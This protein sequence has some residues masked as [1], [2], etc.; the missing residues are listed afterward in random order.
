MESGGQFASTKR[1]GDSL[2]SS[3]NKYS[4]Q[5][6]HYFIHQWRT[7]VRS[8]SLSILPH[9]NPSR[10]CLLAQYAHQVP[11]SVQINIANYILA[12]PTTAQSIATYADPSGHSAL[13]VSH[14]D[15]LQHFAASDIIATGSSAGALIHSAPEVQGISG[16]VITQDDTH[17]TVWG[18][19][20]AKQLVYLT[21][22]TTTL[23]LGQDKPFVLQSTPSREFA[24][25]ISRPDSVTNRPELSQSIIVKN[26]DSQFSM[27][28]Q[29]SNTGLWKSEPFYIQHDTEIVEVPS[30][31]ITIKTSGPDGQPCVAGS[32]VCIKASSA[33]N[34]VVNGKSITIGSVPEWLPLD[35]DGGLHLIVS[36]Q[37][38]NSTTLEINGIRDDKQVAMNLD[39]SVV[40][41]PNRKAMNA[42]GNITDWQV[43]KGAKTQD[44]TPLFDPDQMP[45]DQDLQDAVKYFQTLHS[46]Y[47]SV[48][49]DG[50]TAPAPA[51]QPQPVQKMVSAQPAG[52]FVPAAFSVWDDIAD[53]FMDAF[54]F[55]EQKVDDAVNWVVQV[56]GK[57]LLFRYSVL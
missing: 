33:T 25:V 3:C 9:A 52:T 16:M 55:V 35:N 46:A 19:N 2:G 42:L 31:T 22:T 36:T 47:N 38:F 17:L 57:N 10:R 23:A 43:F 1:R 50:S 20:Q 14:T 11:H 37:G 51:Q 49:A 12:C 27:I 8:L 44:D 30:Y 28:Q 13:L 34:A 41:N 53:D 6:G 29:N 5:W 26:T 54:H 7:K 15:G 18:N 45:S 32:S 40:I 4:W 56:V 48:P 39:S 24:T 21:S